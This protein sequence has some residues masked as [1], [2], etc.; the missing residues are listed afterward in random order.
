MQN[1]EFALRGVGDI[2]PKSFAAAC[3]GHRSIGHQEASDLLAK[4][5]H[6]SLIAGI[7]PPCVHIVYTQRFRRESAQAATPITASSPQALIAYS[8]KTGV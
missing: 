8:A 7:A 3:N 5:A 6:R 1:Q 2:D 4:L